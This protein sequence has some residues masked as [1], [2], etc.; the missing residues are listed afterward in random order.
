M[1]FWN[2]TLKSTTTQQQSLQHA[3]NEAIM[4]VRITKIFQPY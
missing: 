1:A 2:H 3:A 4:L